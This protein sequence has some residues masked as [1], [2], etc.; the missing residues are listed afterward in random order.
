[1][2]F[3]TQRREKVLLLLQGIPSLWNVQEMNY[4]Y[5][6]YTVIEETQYNDSNKAFVTKNYKI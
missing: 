2:K 5:T 4:S 3:T 1:M 6:L